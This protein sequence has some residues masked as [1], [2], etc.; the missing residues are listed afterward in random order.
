M[1]QCMLQPDTAD[2]ACMCGT[3]VS[4]NVVLTDVEPGCE[5]QKVDSAM[6]AVVEDMRDGMQ[7][8]DVPGPS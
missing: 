6:R 7:I 5:P 8:L 2:A 4:L 3:R 1:L